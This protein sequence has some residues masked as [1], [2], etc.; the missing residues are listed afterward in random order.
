[1]RV[2][3]YELVLPLID[4][5]GRAVE[6]REL[7]FNGL[8][9]A[10][11]V[12]DSEEARSVRD[13]ELSRLSPELRD[14]L[15]ARGHLT[16]KGEDEELADQKLVARIGRMLYERMRI[17]PLIMPTYDCNFRC[18]YCYERHRL[19]NAQEWLQTA[20]APDLLDAIF[21][22]LEDH[23][24]RGFRLGTC[25]L[26]GGE[27]LL[28]K[29]VGLVRSICERCKSLG[30]KVGAVTNGYDLD[31]YLDVLE[32][33]DFERLQVT[34]DGV[35]AVNDRLR[36]HKDGAG[37]YE[38][39]MQNIELALERGV[40]VNLRINVGTQ[41]IGGIADLIG[42]LRRRGFLDKEA[43]RAQEAKQGDAPMR[44]SF[45]YYFKA[46]NDADDPEKDLRERD[47]LDELI[48]CGS[49]VDEAIE[50]VSMYSQPADK[51]RA[52]LEKK[53]YPRLEPS[54]CGAQGPMAIFD[55]FGDIYPCFDVVGMDELCIGSVMVPGGKFLWN[56]D[57]AK[58]HLRTSDN[59]EPCMRCPY[60]FACRGGCASRA[61]SAHGTCFVEHCGENRAILD[62]VISRLSEAAYQERG[63]AELSLSL[64]APLSQLTQGQRETLMASRSQKDIYEI[65]AKIGI[66]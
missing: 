65:A 15:L 61:R 22:G 27:P 28:A 55:P 42:D 13:G 30:I 32:E 3:T 29:N 54:F 47:I 58:W 41:N 37:S 45:L 62:Y 25:T 57:K 7:L 33:Y 16:Q 20:M 40:P 52:L 14:R 44:G 39:I 64:A 12:L 60:T 2:S 49:T 5:N 35:G 8:Y 11:D 26:Y 38:R 34:V 51:I 36:V 6:G 23:K 66:I 4:E 50:L 24:E 31:A 19:R 48:R 1:M 17:D 21:E 63:E 10:L 9:G 18:P 59:L 43:R 56:F 46:I 53:G